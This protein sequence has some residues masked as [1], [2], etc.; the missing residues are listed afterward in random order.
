MSY[1]KIANE[2]GAT[3]SLSVLSLSIQGKEAVA[4]L[5]SQFLPEKVARILDR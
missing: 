1:I 3:G 4:L 5:A 2:V